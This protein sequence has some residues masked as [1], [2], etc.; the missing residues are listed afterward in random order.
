M[1]LVKKKELN[2]VDIINSDFNL[3]IIYRKIKFFKFF[4]K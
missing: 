1:K 2:V 3:V 4:Y